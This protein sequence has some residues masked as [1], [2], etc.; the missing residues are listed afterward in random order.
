MKTKS[1]NPSVNN[2]DWKNLSER[3]IYNLLLSLRIFIVTNTLPN[4]SQMEKFHNFQATKEFKG[5][6]GEDT[7]ITLVIANN[8]FHN[9]DIRTKTI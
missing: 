4:W 7:H 9:I 1:L 3:R 2:E 5:S 8:I 6:N